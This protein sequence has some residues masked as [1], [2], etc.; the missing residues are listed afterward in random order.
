MCSASG[1]LRARH[2]PLGREAAAYVGPG[3]GG[4]ARLPGGQLEE[5]GGGG[6]WL[7]PGC[8]GRRPGLVWICVLGLWGAESSLPVQR[9]SP[10]K[11]ALE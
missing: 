5:P 1:Y 10:G 7:G 6:L 2:L 4:V 9:I 3:S 8:E 11:S